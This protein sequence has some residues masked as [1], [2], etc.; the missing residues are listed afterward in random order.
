MEKYQMDLQFKYSCKVSPKEYTYETF[1]EEIQYVV[2]DISRDSF[3]LIEDAVKRP[4]YH[5]TP[6]KYFVISVI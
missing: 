4:K 1:G 6:E 3:S 5:E 2:S